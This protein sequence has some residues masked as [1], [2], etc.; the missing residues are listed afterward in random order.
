MD[1][2]DDAA[3]EGPRQVPAVLPPAPVPVQSSRYYSSLNGGEE[4][5]GRADVFSEGEEELSDES[6]DEQRAAG[7]RSSSEDPLGRSKSRERPR[8]DGARA[9]AGV[10]DRFMAGRET[11]SPFAGG[12][13]KRKS[14]G[15]MEGE[16]EGEVSRRSVLDN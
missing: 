15:A 5:K 16:V 1:D 12:K 7:S 10:L 6:G 11:E 2:E 4:R 14:V 9:T 13:G 8:A 3:S